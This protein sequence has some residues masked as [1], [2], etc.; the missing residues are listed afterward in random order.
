MAGNMR[1]DELNDKLK[2]INGFAQGALIIHSK[3]AQICKWAFNGLVTPYNN[4]AVKA[5]I[6]KNGFCIV[7]LQNGLFPQ[8]WVVFIGGQ[9]MIDPWTGKNVST[10]L[11]G[12]SYIKYIDLTV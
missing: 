2:A 5:Q 12:S 6:K 3:V 7:K 9:R 8:H 4:T 1:S 10:S 11:Y